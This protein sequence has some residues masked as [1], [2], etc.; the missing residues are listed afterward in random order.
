MAS[1]IPLV[2]LLSLGAPQSPA[3]AELDAVATRIEQLKARHAAGEDVGRELLRLLVRAQEL[4]VQIDQEEGRAPLPP[5][6][7]AP[8]SELRERAD[9]LHDEADRIAAALVQLEARIAHAHRIMV[10][11]PQESSPVVRAPGGAVV[12]RNAALSPS[13]ALPGASARQVDEAHVR[14]LMQERARLVVLLAQ[15]RAQAAALDAEAQ[16]AEQR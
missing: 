11:R 9:A 1:G 13:G 15:V 14:A 8:A 4:A 3:R 5:P 7:L 10:A 2:L 16:A 6:A 12:A